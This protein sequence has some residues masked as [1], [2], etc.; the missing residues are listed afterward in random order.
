MGLK[1][2]ISRKFS[3]AGTI[4]S[5]YK[6]GQPQWTPR[7]YESFAK[8]AY[9]INVVAYKCIN[10]IA[11]NIA[12]VPWC[13]YDNNG[14]EIENHELIALLKR[15]NIMQSG[16]EF[17]KALVAYYLV[18]G[19]TYIEMTRKG[20]KPGELYAHRPDYMRVIPG[21]FG[22]PQA[23]RL[24]VNGQFHEWE[25]DAINGFSEIKHFKSFNPL[26]DWY[27]MSPI[28]A[29]A[30]GIDQHN[31]A[32]RHNAAMFQNGL[33]PGGIFSWE[34]PPADAER[35]RFEQSLIDRFQG[36]VNNARPMVVGGDMKY[37]DTTRTQKEVDF[38]GGKKLNAQ[39]ICWALGVN[40]ILLFNESVAYNNIENARL[41]LWEDSCIPI[42]E[43][44]KDGLQSWVAPL[45]GDRGLTIKYDLSETPVMQ[46]RQQITDEAARAAYA[47]A[48]ITRD[49]ARELMGW[50]AVG[51]AKGGDDFGGMFGGLS[52][53]APA[54]DAPADDPLND[55]AQKK[56]SFSTDIEKKNLTNQDAILIVD[57][58][59]QPQVISHTTAIVKRMLEALVMQFGQDVVEEIGNLAAFQATV[60][61]QDFVNQH[62]GE[63]IG[64]INSTTKNA[65]KQQLL[66]GISKSEKVSQL[67]NRVSNV[68][69]AS[70]GARAMTIAQ[71]EA[72]SAAGFGALEAMTQSGVQNMQWFTSFQN[73]RDAHVAMNGQHADVKTGYFFAPS[74]SRTRRPGGFGIASLDINCNC[75]IGMAI[76]D[77]LNTASM[78]HIIEQKSNA[79]WE[80]REKIRLQKIEMIELS[81]KK[82]F[83][84][85]HKAILK[86][87]SDIGVN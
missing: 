54:D 12:S 2:W 64:N 53:S 15:P 27:G 77:P 41:E 65:L 51:G 81:M 57:E 31:A 85:Q 38:I 18:S 8:E 42:L 28:E 7:D 49:E 16:T 26:D 52:S 50:D 40:P 3:A 70:T 17:F 62:T 1:N 43:M 55:S 19:N 61:V 75:A 37:I 76:D 10:L 24:D 66:E 80:R 72:T 34:K 25:V 22:I 74:G 46:K 48:L 9:Q 63:L 45:Y 67:A 47:A 6:V 35:K 32:S 21:R 68:F 58:L 86:R 36:S 30:Y 78:P 39:E 60:R 73:S 82:V 13:V 5:S 84:A 56:S 4:I 87:L 44:L 11:G 71:T 29:A 20:K 23:Y 59:D 33:F 69:T 83:N 79:L 14:N